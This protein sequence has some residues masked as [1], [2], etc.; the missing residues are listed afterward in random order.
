MIKVAVE[1][2]RPQKSIF[3]TNV[4]RDPMTSVHLLLVFVCLMSALSI[5][6]LFAETGNT[7]FPVA[8][9]TTSIDRYQS[10]VSYGKSE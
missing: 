10:Q 6:I 5:A 8:A 4:P 2:Y 3:H 9:Q 7:R 1:S